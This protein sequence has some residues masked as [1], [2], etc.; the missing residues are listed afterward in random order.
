MLHIG[1]YSYADD[2]DLQPQLYESIWNQWAN[3]VQPVASAKPYMTSPGNHEA[4]CRQIGSLGCD[5]RHDNF[6]AYRYRFAM[7]SQESGGVQSMWYSYDVGMVHFVSISTETDFPSAPEGPD[8]LWNGGPFGDQLAWLDADLAAAA[9][10]AARAQ[11]P[12]IIVVGHRPLYTTSAH[13]FPFF[14][15]QN[16]QKYV[17]PLFLKYNVDVYMCGYVTCHLSFGLFVLCIRE[18]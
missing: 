6:T 5:A 16:L 17:E 7:P 10:P 8:T 13:D 12:W 18:R 2:R 1:D 9:A 3:S 11:R 4:S 14:A 15:T